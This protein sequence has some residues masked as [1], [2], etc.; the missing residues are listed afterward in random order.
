[1]QIDLANCFE[2]GAVLIVLVCWRMKPAKSSFLLLCILLITLGVEFTS[3]Y[4]NQ[5][6]FATGK[7]A[8]YATAKYAMYSLFNIVKFCGFVWFIF[9]LIQDYK[10]RKW[11]ILISS[12][13]FVF[14]AGNITMGQGYKTYNN[15]SNVVGIIGLTIVALYQ[16]RNFEDLDL[17]RQSRSAV[18]LYLFTLFFYY[19]IN[20]PVYVFFEQMFAQ[21]KSKAVS[22]YRLINDTANYFFYAALVVAT[23]LFTFDT[24]R[25]ET[26]KPQIA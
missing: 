23:I 17:S 14:V 11:Y 5:L 6:Y 18:L 1:M 8:S 19:S 21:E 7:D 16:L 9:F 20:L 3:K 13:I 22:T 25:N 4:L 24:H 26:L 2:I 15:Y 12:I 10:N